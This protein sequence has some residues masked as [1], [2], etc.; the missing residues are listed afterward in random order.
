MRHGD[1][2]SSKDTVGVAVINYKMPRLHDKKGVIENCHNIAKVMNGIK[3]GYPGLDLIVFPEYSTQGIIY[4]EK[5]MYET[6][7]DVPGDETNIFSEACKNLKIW[8]VFFNN[9][10]KTR[11]TS[12]KNTL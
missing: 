1:I 8:G 4:D 12:A 3:Q 10:R 5:E 9:G 6:A 2:S 11:K 7:I